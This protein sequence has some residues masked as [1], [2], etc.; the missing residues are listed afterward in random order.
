MLIGRFVLKKSRLSKPSVFSGICQEGKI[1]ED[2]VILLA[3]GKDVKVETQAFS[4]LTNLI[5][6]KTDGVEIGTCPSPHILLH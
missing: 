6:T 1:G 2:F 4:D 3:L 5:D